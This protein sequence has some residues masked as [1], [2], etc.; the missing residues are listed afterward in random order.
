[1]RKLYWVFLA[2]MLVQ[3]QGDR[4]AEARRQFALNNPPRE[5]TGLV[6]LPDLGKQTY[7][8][9][10]GGL[11][12]DGKNTPPSSHRKAGVAIAKRIAPLDGEGQ[13]SGD[14]KIV[15]LSIGMSNT[16]QE[17]QVFRQRAAGEIGLNPH[18][19]IVD[20]AQGGQAADTTA[21]PKAKFWDVVEQRLARADATPK[22]VQVVWL[23]QAI[24]APKEAFPAEA[25]KLQGF[26]EATLNNLSARY[27][28][29]KL[30]Y[31]SSRIYAGYALTPLNPEPHAYESGFA[32]KWL[33]A[34][35][36]AGKLE[37]NYDAAKG[38]VRAPWVAWGPYLWTDGMKGRKDGL[39]FSKQDLEERDGTHPAMPG[40]GKV[41]GQLLEFFKK[42]E[43]ARPWFSKAQ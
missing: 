27:P 16:T 20:G 41:A 21:N 24:I 36:I 40:R 4:G 14:G 42:D 29:L 28:N 43:T 34:D 26:L 35:Q 12:A 7:H 6:P 39:V 3:G 22:Q 37:L 5:S 17:F 8:G 38:A 2:A 11:Y 13:R 32:V 9:H 15:L 18:L 33:I 19:L 10:T 30:A 25:K 23:K 31:L 1:M